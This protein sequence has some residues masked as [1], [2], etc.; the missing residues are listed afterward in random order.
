MP[1]PKTID[2]NE[3]FVIVSFILSMIIIFRL[4]NRFPLSVIIL[5]SL[6]ASVI[7]RLCDHLLAG[8]KFDFYDL[9]DTG[10][11][12]LFDLFTYFLYIPFIYLFIYFYDKWRLQ[13]V[14]V[15]F[16]IIICTFIGTTFEWISSLFKVFNY[17]TWEISYSFTVYFVIQ[18]IT[19]LFFEFIKKH[20]KS[21]DN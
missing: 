2:F 19:L 12:D 21:Y 14:R 7:A 5:L 8:P 9:M 20:H 15:L 16:Y 11:Y 1:L 4:P 3:W 18:P 10:K 13:G 6:F 17:K